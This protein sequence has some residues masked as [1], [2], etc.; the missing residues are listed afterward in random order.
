MLL[1][2]EGRGVK[3]D[4]IPNV[5][6]LEFSNVPVK[7]WIIDSLICMAFM[8]VLEVLCTSLSTIEKL[9]TL[10]EYREELPWS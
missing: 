8:M 2:M 3:Q 5:R 4:L 1:E 9:F 7:G 10:M 6:Q